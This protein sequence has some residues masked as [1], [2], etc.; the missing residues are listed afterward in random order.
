M[1]EFQNDNIDL[2]NFI[3]KKKLENIENEPKKFIFYLL[4]V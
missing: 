3:N 1:D 2:L 4:K